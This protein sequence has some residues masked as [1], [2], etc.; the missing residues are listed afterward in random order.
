MITSMTVLQ[1]SVPDM[2]R[3]RVMGIHTIGYSLI[4]LG[5]LFVGALTEELGAAAAVL[6]GCTVYLLV[7]AALWLGG[8]E[9]RGLSGDALAR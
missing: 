5:G 7:I 6:A 8:R 2:L 3:G 9:V 4:P 1:L